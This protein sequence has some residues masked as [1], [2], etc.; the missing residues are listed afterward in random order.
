MPQPVAHFSA[1][2]NAVMLKHSAEA[3]SQQ[4]VL[5]EDQSVFYTSADQVRAA[6][7]SYGSMPLIVLTHS[8]FPKGQNETQAERD[9]R[10]KLWET[11]HDELAALST[12]GAHRVIP[13]SGHFIQW[14]Q[15]QA[16]I[17]AVMDCLNESEK[18]I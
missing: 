8:S 10:T 2:L 15:P 5:S 12:R 6:R 4:A 18:R 14:D 11:L 9:E 3:S 7:R 17:D 1:A 13:D 16:V